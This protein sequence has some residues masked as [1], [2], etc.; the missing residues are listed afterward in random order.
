MG[1]NDRNWHLNSHHSRRAGKT[2]AVNPA[3]FASQFGYWAR[4][5]DFGEGLRFLVSNNEWKKRGESA[6]DYVKTNHGLDIVV[7]KY[8]QQCTELLRENPGLCEV[9]PKN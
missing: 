8:I 1:K 4:K 9:V 5:D 2:S 3:G 6:H 7:K